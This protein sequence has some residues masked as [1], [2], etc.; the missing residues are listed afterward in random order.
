[1]T[2]SKRTAGGALP[3]ATL[4]LALSSLFVFATDRGY[5]HEHHFMDSNSARSLA[6]TAGMTLVGG[7]V[8][9]V[10]QTKR[11]PDGRLR[12]VVYGRFPPGGYAL[13][14]LAMMPFEGDLSAQILAARMVMLAFL[15][16]AAVL[17]CRT[18]AH[19]TGDPWVGCAATLLV[20]SAYYMLN[21]GAMINSEGSID[22]FAVLL[23]AHG[24]VLWRQEDRFWQLLAKVC[25][26]LLLGWHVYGL[27]LAFIAL[28][29]GSEV[30][31]VWRGAPGA[32][33][34]R[35]ARNLLG[36]AL[37]S[38]FTLLG[39]AAVVF[40]VCVLGYN[41]A[42]ELALYSDKAVGELPLARS[43]FRRT[44]WDSGHAEAFA[45][46]LAWPVYLKWQFHR[47]GG[48]SLPYVL[49]WLPTTWS[50]L[51]VESTA[52]PLAWVGVAV[53]VACLGGIFFLRP[54]RLLAA[55]VALSGL[56]WA[57]P[58][59]H[60]TAD[61]VHHYESMFYFG[62]PLM[63]FALLLLGARRFVGRGGMA[64]L[65]A[66]AVIVFVLSNHRIGGA[67]GRPL[68]A[69]KQRALL[70]E[71]DAIREHA[72][73]KAVLVAIHPDALVRLVVAR[74]AFWFYMA[75]SVLRYDHDADAG[76]RGADL[77]LSLKRVPTPSLLTPDHRFV[78]LYDSVAA[79]DAITAAH[80]REYEALAARRPD[81][82]GVFD[83]YLREGAIAYRKAPCAAS[84][85][86]G[87]FFLHLFPVDARDLNAADR[88]VGFANLDF[89]FGAHG[90]RVDGKCMALV[91][92]PA[93]DVAKVRTGRMTD[94]RGPVLWQTMFDT[95]EGAAA[96]RRALAAVWGT[97]PVAAGP[98]DV[99]FDGET[100]TYLAPRC[101]NANMAARFFLHVV[102]NDPGHLPKE[103]RAHGFANLDFHFNER[104]AVIEEACVATARLPAWGVA[105]IRTGQHNQAASVLWRVEFA[106]RAERAHAT[107]GG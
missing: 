55:T 62:L 103:R 16:A 21:A 50:E 20:F 99:Y 53:T 86:D 1:M 102:P 77:V 58:M 49:P 107:D 85:T 92:R 41:L 104:G 19:L 56:C 42:A 68:A 5:I 28:G 96:L 33:L 44:G 83:I 52:A 7:L 11:R 100:V 81:A 95:A 82:R 18:V 75:G 23:V 80:R 22:L 78:F 93:F 61:R 76:E 67:E 74:Y 60:H 15:A 26:A 65:A 27:L 10:V 14:R 89:A 84:D 79:V 8:T 106:G 105:S 3:L 32:P 69:A 87:R 46:V 57:L 88:L 70:A 63:L 66:V 40:G 30:V 91:P 17:A 13:L 59:R 72:R 37:R 39:A 47:I 101:A 64:A 4:L 54:H 51:P 38:R 35:L 34:G 12:H 71:F 6:H 97:Q 9:Q 45:Q 36:Q 2:R 25:V 24:M 48:M 43:I 29:L 90:V 73:G 31:A 94:P 98:F